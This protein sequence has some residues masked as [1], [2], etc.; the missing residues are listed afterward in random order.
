LGFDFQLPNYQ[1]TNLL[2][3]QILSEN[4]NVC[5]NNENKILVIAV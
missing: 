5:F 3:Y 4:K 1:I 2:N